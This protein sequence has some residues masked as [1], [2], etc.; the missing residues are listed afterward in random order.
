MRTRSGTVRLLDNPARSTTGIFARR[1]EGLL[2]RTPR[3]FDWPTNPAGVTSVAG[4]AATNCT[5]PRPISG[6]AYILWTN[7]LDRSP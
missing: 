1:S 5:P 3:P 2:W 7:H 4:G 6:S